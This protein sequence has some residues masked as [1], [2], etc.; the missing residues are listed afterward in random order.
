M[1][2]LL[3]KV[4]IN[5]VGVFAAIQVIPQIE[6]AFGDD[7]WKLLA[8]ALILALVNSYVKPILKALSFPITLLSLGLFSF[9]LNALLLLLVAL[10]SDQ[11]GLGFSIGGFPPDLT[12]DAFV[13]ALL[14][15]IVISIVSTLLGMI[16]SGRKVVA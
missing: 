5:A 8:V 15:A 14:G 11:L 4:L 12:A 9:I 10:V 3:V 2:D 1:I 16:N 7:W 13:G 6:F